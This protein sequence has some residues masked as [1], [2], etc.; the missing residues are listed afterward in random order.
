MEEQQEDRDSFALL[1]QYDDLTAKKVEDLGRASETITAEMKALTA[2]LDRLKALLE[3]GNMKGR[4][5]TL[6]AEHEQ[7]NMKIA[8]FRRELPQLKKECEAISRTEAE[9]SRI[10]DEYGRVISQYEDLRAKQDSLSRGLP[11]IEANTSECKKT[12]AETENALLDLSTAR[13]KM[14]AE[15]NALSAK[16]AALK[17]FEEAL[18]GANSRLAN[19]RDLSRGTVKTQVS[20]PLYIAELSALKDGLKRNG[21]QALL[22]ASDLAA[23]L[24]K[25]Y[26]SLGGDATELLRMLVSRLSL[27]QELDGKEKVYAA[28]SEENGALQGEAAAK[29][30][31][32]DELKAL[33]SDDKKIVASLETEL[34]RYCK[35]TG[36]HA[37]EASKGDEMSSRKEAAK[38]EFIDLFVRKAELEDK[39]LTAARVMRELKEMAKG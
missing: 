3:T 24:D 12:I 34:A 35:M 4:L 13:E 38:A 28:L 23:R 1:A 30:T 27:A 5:D 36:E 37:T 26:G 16:I 15:A 39:V 22:H 31:E 17:Q 19:S 32:L 18:P 33:N 7:N 20:S 9:L 29:H 10:E 6:Y 25:E 2:E 14:E 11:G 21:P 8:E